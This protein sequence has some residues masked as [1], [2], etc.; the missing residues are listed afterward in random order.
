MSVMLACGHA[1]NAKDEHGNPVC[2]ICYGIVAGADVVVEGPDLT[3]RMA[4]CDCGR[5]VPSSTNLP[6]FQYGSWGGKQPHDR[7]YCGCRGWN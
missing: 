4:K 6:F 3:G 1:A 2:V 7:F 5:T